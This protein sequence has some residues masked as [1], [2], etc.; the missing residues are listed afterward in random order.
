MFTLFTSKMMRL[1][2][3]AACVVALVSPWTSHA[4]ETNTTAFLCDRQIQWADGTREHV[5]VGRDGYFRL[6]GK[7][8]RL[9]GIDIGTT[10]LSNAYFKANSLAIIDKELSYLETAGMRVIHANF[11]Y[12]GYRKEAECYRP[13]LDLLYKHKMLAFPLI[14]GKW[15]PYFGSLTHAD[16]KIDGIDSLSQWAV[17]WCAV[18]TNY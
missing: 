3:L 6:D 12:A 14:S 16:F 2:F 13:L 9:V 17:R 10:G 11:G 4:A 8:V 18:M 15:L 5:Q 1:S 7:K